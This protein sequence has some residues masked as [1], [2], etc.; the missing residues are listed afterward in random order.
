MLEITSLSTIVHQTNSYGR[1]SV[2][3]LTFRVPKFYKT[4]PIIKTQMNP[5]GAEHV[6]FT[7]D[8]HLERNSVLNFVSLFPCSGKSLL[9]CKVN[10][11]QM[12]AAIHDVSLL[13]TIEK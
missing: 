4:I 1:W 11:G 6:F 7:L 3:Q 8:F 5:L 12:T 9:C 2:W 13:P 10:R